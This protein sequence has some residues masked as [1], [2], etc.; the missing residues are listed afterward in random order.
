M[1]SVLCPRGHG[2]EPPPYASNAESP[3]VPFRDAAQGTK[4]T[5]P[6]WGERSSGGATSPTSGAVATWEPREGHKELPQNEEGF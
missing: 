1:A 5:L 6:Q 2:L 3:A 4:P